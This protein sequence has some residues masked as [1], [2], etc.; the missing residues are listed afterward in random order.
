MCSRRASVCFGKQQTDGFHQLALDLTT[1]ALEKEPLG[2]D[3]VNCTGRVP[4][5][6]ELRKTLQKEF[7]FEDRLRSTAL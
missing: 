6:L 5:N 1:D 7:T 4:Y 2:V 3:S